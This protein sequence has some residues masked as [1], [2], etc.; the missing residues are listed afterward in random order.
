MHIGT[1]HGNPNS[2][3]SVWLWFVVA[4]TIQFDGL[5]TN[6]GEAAAAGVISSFHDHFL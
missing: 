3:L 6:K 4:N 1:L 5:R 2:L